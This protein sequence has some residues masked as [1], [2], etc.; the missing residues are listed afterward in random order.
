[1][2]KNSIKNI[3]SWNTESEYQVKKI[4]DLLKDVKKFINFLENKFDFKKDYPLINLFMVRK[5]NL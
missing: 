2:S 3:T 5:R 1:M 4:K